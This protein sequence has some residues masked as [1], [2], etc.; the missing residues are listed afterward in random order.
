[1]LGR[2]TVD[3]LAMMQEAFGTQF[4][5]NAHIAEWRPRLDQK[6][7]HHIPVM[8]GVI[9]L[10]DALRQNGKHLAVATSATR[11]S[12]EAYL[13]TAGLRDYFSHV[14]TRDDV[15]QGKPH[16]EPFQKAAAALSIAPE[17]CIALEDT[18]AGIRSAH[19]AGAIPI[20]IP[21]L[22]QPSAKV[23]DLCHV[24]CEDMQEVHAHLRPV[25]NV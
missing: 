8:P 16:P 23:A 3:C 11:K 6:L 14:V 7:Q 13:T 21:S 19:G 4:D 15:T 20:M 24:L 18:E 22:K 5:V 9:A 10:L 1:M 2:P 17:R 12:A 25:L